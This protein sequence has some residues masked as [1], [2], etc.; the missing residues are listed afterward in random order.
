MIWFWIML[1]VLALYVLFLFTCVFTT[2]KPMHHVE[3]DEIM[4]EA[5]LK[6]K[7]YEDKARDWTRECKE[8]G[9]I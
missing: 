2:P 5:R 9:K 4:T 8:K 7:E 3:A 6:L 1:A